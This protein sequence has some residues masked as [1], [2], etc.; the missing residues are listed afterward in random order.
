MSWRFADSYQHTETR[1]LHLW[2]KCKYSS[3]ISGT[4]VAIWSKTSFRPTGHHHLRSSPFPRIC[5]VPSA[6][7]FLKWILDCMELSTTR[8]ATNCMAK[9]FPIILWNQDQPLHYILRWMIAVDLRRPP[10]LN[11]ERFTSITSLERADSNTI[12]TPLGA[13]KRSRVH[14]W[15]LDGSH[16]RR[17]IWLHVACLDT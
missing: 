13:R 4:C 11:I 3:V 7:S 5:T 15:R 12:I 2:D 10:R 14:R 16:T 9:W 1:C 8:E 6:S 17:R